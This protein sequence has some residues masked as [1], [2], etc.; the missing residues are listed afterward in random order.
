LPWSE[1]IRSSLHTRL[2]K[3]STTCVFNETQRIGKQSRPAPN[4]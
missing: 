3:T 4:L 2:S 1:Q